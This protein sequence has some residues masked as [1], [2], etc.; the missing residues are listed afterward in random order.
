LNSVAVNTI[1]GGL[2]TGQTVTVTLG[3]YISSSSGA[4]TAM[5]STTGQTLSGQV[6]VSYTTASSGSSSLYTEIA[7][8]NIKVS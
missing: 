4:V 3:N 5:P 7:T 8:A 1:S 6:W 2:S